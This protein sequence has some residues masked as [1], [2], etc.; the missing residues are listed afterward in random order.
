MRST[1]CLKNV[2]P[3]STTLLRFL[4]SQ[5]EAL[6]F[7]SQNSVDTTYIPRCFG[8]RFTPSYGT[9]TLEANL[10]NLD[11]FFP[12]ASRCRK[13][14]GISSSRLKTA[15]GS[16]RNASSTS[17]KL[18]WFKKIW[19]KERDECDR[20]RSSSRSSYDRST[21]NEMFGHGRSVLSKAINEPRLRCTELDEYGNVVLAS[22]E[23]K[24][25]ELI[26]R[27]L[28]PYLETLS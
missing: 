2:T 17:P 16:F 21:D 14:A 3:P 18:G 10:L 5:S 12:R 20:Q 1:S 25:T 9:A 6:C 13:P 22:G 24:K 28:F 23:F 8:E 7:F 4:R 27:V 19:K 26:A 15:V 11:F